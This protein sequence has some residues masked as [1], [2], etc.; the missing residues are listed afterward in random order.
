MLSDQELE[1][2]LL[3]IES[4]RVERKKD[5]SGK[6]KDKIREAICA[7]ANDMPYNQQ[8]GVI[9]IGVEDDGSCA[10]IQVSDE[11]LKT[12]SDMRSDGNTLPFPSITVQ[13]HTL[14]GC[15]MAVI[16]VEP[17]YNPPVRYDG[18]VCIRIG[19]R[20]AVA[21]VEEER[22]L[23]ER[24]RSNNLP[25]DQQEVKGSNLGDL[26]L[27]SFKKYYLPSAVAPDIL[28]QNHRPL[29]QQLASLRFLSKNLIPNNAAILVLGKDPVM[30]LPGAYIQFLRFDGTNLTDPIK[31][32]REVSGPLPD[33]LRQFNEI[34]E[35]NISISS[36]ITK[37]PTELRQPDYP[38]VALQQLVYNA[39]LH[40]NYDSSNAP[41][42]VYWFSDRI[43]IYSPGGPYG[44]VNVSNFG[45]TGV[46]DYRNPLLA[47]AMKELGYVQRFG[48]GIPTAKDQ[49]K[50][51]GNPELHFE[52]QSAIILATVRK[53]G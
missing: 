25:F 31:S 40:R 24:Q 4:D 45:Q 3:D 38:I 11:L 41:V 23:I 8:P 29:E 5:L 51:N 28:A 50:K 1:S 13:K 44:Q 17:A 42:K 37:G 26:D 30:W 15:E 43:E 33:I 7:F 20:R 52:V 6:V 9:F 2:L 19:P 36:N 39:V 10:N 49:L 48:I 22:R 12:L 16:Q 14:R 21:S 27:D 32:Q 53:H 47:E 46:T 34:L 35:A 18:K